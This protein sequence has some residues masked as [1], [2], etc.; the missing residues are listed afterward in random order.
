MA[1]DPKQF[2]ELFSA[3]SNALQVAA[4][5]ATRLRRDLGEQAQ[6]ALT[7]EAAVDRAVRAVRQFRPDG[8]VR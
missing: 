3:L 8:D 5:L 4:L 1:I 7:L 2:S 6:D